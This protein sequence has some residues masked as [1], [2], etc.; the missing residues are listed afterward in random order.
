MKYE[1]EYQYLPSG[2]QR[3]IDDGEVIGI[4]ATDESG[5]VLL[6]NVGDYVHIENSGGRASFAG[7]VRSRFFLYVCRENKE[8][9]CHVNIVVEETDDDFGKLLK[10]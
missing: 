1:I 7:K 3:P 10:M 8:I 5:V 6:P 9:Y 2:K 4:Q